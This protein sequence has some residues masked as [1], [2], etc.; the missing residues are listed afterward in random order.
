MAA[1]AFKISKF[2]NHPQS[3]SKAAGSAALTDK[4]IGLKAAKKSHAGIP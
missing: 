2:S 1:M 3:N 4:E